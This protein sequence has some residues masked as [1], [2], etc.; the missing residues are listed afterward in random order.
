MSLLKPIP[1]PKVLIERRVPDIPFPTYRFVP[2]LHEHPNQSTEHDF[3]NVSISQCWDYGWD[4]YNHH[5]WW[6]AHEV[7]ERLWK[8]LP[9]D[10]SE[11]WSNEHPK[12]RFVQGHILLSACK[13]LEHLGRP[14][15]SMLKKAHQYLAM[16]E[17]FS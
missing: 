2:G 5:Y 4:L 8:A 11:V 13:L 14:K 7:W 10:S 12:R 17:S 1:A 6:E 16:G 15:E 3:P 9:L